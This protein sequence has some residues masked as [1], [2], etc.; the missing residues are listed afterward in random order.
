[1][2]EFLLFLQCDVAVAV[3]SGFAVG[4]ITVGEVHHL[5]CH[6]LIGILTGT[7]AL[8]LEERVNLTTEETSLLVDFDL[9]YGR[10]GGDTGKTH[11][12]GCAEITKA[13]GDEATFID[14]CGTYHMG[15]MTIDDVSTVVNTE[16]GK[17][18]KGAA[19]LSQEALR[20]LWEMTLGTSLGT[21]ME[22][23]DNDVRFLLQV[24]DDTLDG[25]QVTM[26]EGVLVMPAGA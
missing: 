25:L 23:D 12:V 11:A 20:T 3:D 21:A 2:Y 8:L 4:D 5:M 10:V 18:T 24:V 19:V 26:L 22:G 17:L 6:M 13:V 14:F 16:M 1:M 15:T 9:D 7:N